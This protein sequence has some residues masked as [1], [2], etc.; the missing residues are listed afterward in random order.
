MALVSLLLGQSQRG[1]RIARDLT[2]AGITSSIFLDATVQEEFDAPSEVTQYPVEAGVDISDHIILKSRKLSISGIVSETPYTI[3]AQ[4]SGVA[5]TVA[6][7]I[8]QSLGGAVGATFGAVGVGKAITMAGLLTPKS[9]TNQTLVPDDEADTRSRN[10]LPG[11]N[12]RLRDAIEE[13]MNLRESRQPVTII[14]GLKMYIDYAMMDCKIS[15]DKN[16]GQS[17]SVA[18]T[19]MEIRVSKTEL[20]QISVPAQKSG[21]NQKNS[22]HQSLLP[23][24]GPGQSIFYSWQGENIK[25]FLGR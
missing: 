3:G 7:R 20:T 15:R 11:E 21:L 22:G 2:K 18:L 23:P 10:N 14:T 13:F 16:S 1:T 17:I 12:L 4:V 25:N 6:S 5:S 8:G 24:A 9:V 19:F